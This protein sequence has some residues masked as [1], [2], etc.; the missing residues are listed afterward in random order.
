MAIFKDAHPVKP[1]RIALQSIAKPIPKGHPQLCPNVELTNV[2]AYCERFVTLLNR[3]AM[4]QMATTGTLALSAT[5]RDID[6]NTG[7]VVYARHDCPA[8]KITGQPSA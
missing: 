1:C 8:C 7:K 2:K 4:I 6:P 5:W 3:I